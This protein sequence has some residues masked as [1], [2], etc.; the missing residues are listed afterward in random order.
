MADPEERSSVGRAP[1]G[2][3][4]SRMVEGAVRLLATKGVE[5]TSFAEVLEA[6]SFMTTEIHGN[7]EA[8]W[9]NAPEEE[10]D[11]ARLQADQFRFSALVETIASSPQFLNKRIQPVHDT[12]ESVQSG[13]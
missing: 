12:A 1:R 8:F 11:K 4:R 5:G 2:A 3:V 6:T 13:R 10:K 9:K 7:F